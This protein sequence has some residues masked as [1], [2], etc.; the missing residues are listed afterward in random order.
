MTP[1]EALWRTGKTERVGKDWEEEHCKMTQDGLE[2]TH[3][4]IF[5]KKTAML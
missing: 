4:Q 5:S 3:E 1:L 2:A